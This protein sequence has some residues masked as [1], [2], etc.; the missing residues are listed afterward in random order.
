MT[1]SDLTEWRYKC[2][3]DSVSASLLRQFHIVVCACV[4]V[5]AILN[6]DAKPDYI[7]LPPGHTPICPADRLNVRFSRCSE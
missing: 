4:I 2:L 7:H 5:L 3:Q 1:E 6:S